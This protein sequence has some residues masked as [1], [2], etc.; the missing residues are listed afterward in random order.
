[1]KNETIFFKKWLSSGRLD[2]HLAKTLLTGDV[3]LVNCI[4]VACFEW[5]V[6]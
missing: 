4:I 6:K 5:I 1:M 2:A 3:Q